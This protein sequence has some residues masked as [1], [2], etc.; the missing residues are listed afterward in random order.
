MNTRFTT[1]DERFDQFF[2]FLWA[3]I[4]IFTA[5]MVSVFGFAYWDRKLSLRPMKA[6]QRKIYWVFCTIMPNNNPASAKS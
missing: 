5:M 1:M 3:I 6:E 4:G 2:N